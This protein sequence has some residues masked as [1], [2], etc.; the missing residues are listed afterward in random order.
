MNPCDAAKARTALPAAPV[1]D[2][3]R[4]L[5]AFL[6][7]DG[8]VRLLIWSGAVVLTCLAFRGLGL[9]PRAASGPLAEPAWTWLIWISAWIALFNL[10]YVGIL[11]L[12]RLLIPT[13]RE[14][15][16]P[17]V[18]RGAVDRQVLW[19]C[20][21]AIL[22]K[23]RHQAPFPGFLVHTVAS[24]PP[25]RGL[26]DHTLGPRSRSCNVVD[27]LIMDPH[28]VT[29]GR[30]VVI[31]YGAVFTAHVQG[32]DT[33]ALRRIVVEDDVVIGGTA[34]ILAGARI[35][36]GAV[37]GAG[38]IVLPGTVVGANEFWAGVP[39]KKIRDLPPRTAQPA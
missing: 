15:E 4:M 35:G 27:P 21:L 30:N 19:Q 14:G 6:L 9:W 16:Y 25:L 17:L 24:L 32:R 26:V 20:L 37:I 38:A 11:V 5:E 29:I 36:A 13:P 39:A 3:R 10:V 2:S 28:L 12:L 22:T 8:A 7:V 31:G 33:L 18:C 34:Q 23:A 1:A